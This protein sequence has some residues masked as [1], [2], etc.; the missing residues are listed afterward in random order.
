[1]NLSL[2][3]RQ[4]MSVFFV[5]LTVSTWTTVTAG[6]FEL[7]YQLNSPNATFYGGQVELS[8]NSLLVGSEGAFYLYDA[9]TGALLREYPDEIPGVNPRNSFGL[10]GN[11]AVFISDVDNQTRVVKSYNTD[12]NDPPT[13]I[14]PLDPNSQNL[15]GV[16]P[17]TNGA[18]I[19]VGA[20]FDNNMAGAVYLFDR[21][22]GDQ[23]AKL[24]S[25][26]PLTHG[27]FGNDLSIGD[28]WLAVADDRFS[29]S[30]IVRIYDLATLQEQTVL[31]TPEQD[32]SF[33]FAIDVHE[34]L[35]IT[36]APRTNQQSGKA[37]VNSAVTGELISVL[38]PNDSSPFS[39]FG[40][41]VS[42]HGDLAIV[43][44]TEANENLGAAYI[45][46]VQ[47]GEQLARL[48]PSESPQ[49]SE[50]GE[51][52]AINDR[53]AVVGNPFTRAS[54]VYSVPEPCLPLFAMVLS[55]LAFRAGMT[56]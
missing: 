39:D 13:Q 26:V 38:E 6:T 4:L 8:G 43:G 7:L 19:A 12:T 10:S 33:G 21:D 14:I 41:A 48:L 5:T 15:F 32:D 37:Y 22:S 50:F 2:P 29:L 42:I 28:D 49:R 44:A 52:V 56:R 18:T 9:V 46:D 36:G 11:N 25:P 45:F 54:Y 20:P 1:M 23:L 53:F 34:D 30:G 51:S 24:E 35:V 17:D 55:L 31:A 40:E 3:F 47:T 27:L 16:A